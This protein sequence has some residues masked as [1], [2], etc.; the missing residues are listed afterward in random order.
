MGAARVDE[1][2]HGVRPERH[3]RHQLAVLAVRLRVVG[4]LVVGLGIPIHAEQLRAVC[5]VVPGPGEIRQAGHERVLRI[6]VRR[7]VIAGP[8][9][10]EPAARTAA[11]QRVRVPGR[12]WPEERLEVPLQRLAE[13]VEDGR[14]HAASRHD[15]VHE[16]PRAEGECRPRGQ[17]KGNVLLH[18]IPLI[19][20]RRRRDGVEHHLV[21]VVGQQVRHH[22][23]VAGIRLERRRGDG[24]PDVR[25]HPFFVQDVAGAGRA[26]PAA[27]RRTARPG[28]RGRRAARSPPP[29]SWFPAARRGG[30]P[31]PRSDASVP[32]GAAG[33]PLP[34]RGGQR[35]SGVSRTQYS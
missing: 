16:G 12:L 23:V 19:E 32:C 18:R 10:H 33:R 4:L 6:P 20:E 5:L 24:A 8:P 31:R 13:L 26:R 1:R 22:D 34:P 27:R 21:D 28:Q 29:W 3:A 2:Q 30:A 25:Q 15:L 11:R 35:P 9:Q 7:Q 17:R 14:Q